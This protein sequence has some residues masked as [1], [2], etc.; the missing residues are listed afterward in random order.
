MLNILKGVGGGG[1]GHEGA[2]GRG[3]EGENG[4]EL[5]GYIFVSL[6]FSILFPFFPFFSLN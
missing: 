6:L 3:V 4:V 5:P 1:G 2:W